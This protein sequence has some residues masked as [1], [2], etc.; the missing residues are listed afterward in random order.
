LKLPRPF[1]AAPLVLV[2]LAA[3]P[4]PCGAEAPSRALLLLPACPLEGVS[5]QDLR[6]ALALELEADGVALAKPG[7][8]FGRS[9]VLLEI[10]SSCHPGTELSL[11]VLFHD[12]ERARSLALA[13]LPPG[14]RSRML[15]L[16][17]AELVDRLDPER[18]PAA[19]PALE[20]AEPPD[21]AEAPPAPA[22]E[23]APAP[24]P[25]R[26]PPKAPTPAVPPEA[27][28]PAKPSEP[29]DDFTSGAP[30]AR[31]TAFGIAPELRWFTSGSSL[32]GGRLA[33]DT[34]R[35]VFGAGLL[36]G[37]S[38]SDVGDVDALLVQGLVGYRVVDA[39][40]GAG[41]STSFG[42][43]LGFGWVEVTG[44]SS[45]AEVTA[46]SAGEPYIDAS[47]FAELRYVVSPHFH[48]SLGV[49]GGVSH[50]LVALA[51]GEPVASYDGVFV[52]GFLRLM[53]SP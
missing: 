53:L 15:A 5:E 3:T 43:R 16:S 42:P 47:A 36:V 7:D 39:G 18:S 27:T 40:L 24:A 17:L 8:G 44:S 50:G 11:R 34:A 35:L 22:A 38:G 41:F 29:V 26:S 49:E 10:E 21:S 1:C 4:S 12:R 2:I 20:G 52:A 30:P 14:T 13:D 9:D 48:C 31:R 33:L 25:A 45:D 51:D 37:S 19:T 23:S 32:F 6:A 28:E 46:T